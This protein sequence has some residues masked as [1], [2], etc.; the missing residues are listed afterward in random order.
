MVVWKD[1][2]L[3]LASDT[4]LELMEVWGRSTG[5]ASLAA[6]ILVVYDGWHAPAPA[7]TQD[8]AVA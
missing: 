4:P 2:R 5:L 8:E 7:E 6:S 1:D 3:V